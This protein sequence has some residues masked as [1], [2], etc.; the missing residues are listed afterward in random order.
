MLE[1]DLWKCEQGEE[2]LG[3][4]PMRD[5]TEEEMMMMMMMMMMMIVV[6]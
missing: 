4:H 6:G 2:Y 5:R 3:W 1:E